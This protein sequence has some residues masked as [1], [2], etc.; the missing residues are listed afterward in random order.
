M[1]LLF[2]LIWGWAGPVWVMDTWYNI[3]DNR[4]GERRSTLNRSLISDRQQAKTVNITEGHWFLYRPGRNFWVGEIRHAD[5]L[6]E[7]W[8][9]N[10]CLASNHLSNHRFEQILLVVIPLSLCSKMR[11]A[12]V[13]LNTTIVTQD[14]HY[15]ITIGDPTSSFHHQPPTQN[16]K[17]HLIYKFTF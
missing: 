5:E 13:Q 10:I 3:N 12:T 1:N 15:V 2:Y 17:I 16:C 11:F 7:R 9:Y 6:N 4:F 14:N 8:N